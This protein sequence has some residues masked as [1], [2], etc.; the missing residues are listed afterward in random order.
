[1]ILR[2]LPLISTFILIVEGQSS[3][4]RKHVLMRCADAFCRGKFVLNQCQVRY[5]IPL[6]SGPISVGKTLLSYPAKNKYFLSFGKGQDV[7]IYGKPADKVTSF[8]FVGVRM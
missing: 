4:E 6:I 2:F 8:A 1:M 5:L 7:T 3:I